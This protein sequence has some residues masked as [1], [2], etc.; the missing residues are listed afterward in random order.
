[1]CGGIQLCSSPIR[2]ILCTQAHQNQD[3]GAH[4]LQILVSFLCSEKTVSSMMS[5]LSITKDVVRLY[6]YSG[7][8]LK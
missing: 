8:F 2:S 4:I 7:V 1:M 5:S 3:G 6:H